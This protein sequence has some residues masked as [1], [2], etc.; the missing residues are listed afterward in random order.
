MLFNQQPAHTPPAEHRP[1]RWQ[2]KDSPS[3]GLMDSGG[4]RG[5]GTG[6]LN[7]R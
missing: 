7:G 3:G 2:P 4:Q 5:N 1:M 6:F